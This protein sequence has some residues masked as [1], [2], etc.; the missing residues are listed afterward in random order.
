MS[1]HWDGC[2][3]IHPGCA[4]MELRRVQAENARLEREVARHSHNGNIPTQFGNTVSGPVP[5]FPETFA[6]RINAVVESLPSAV[7]TLTHPDFAPY[8]AEMALI[9]RI[10]GS[11]SWTAPAVDEPPITLDASEPHR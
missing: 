10:P 3:N 1:D 8:T 9:Q 5:C 6:E 4:V 2:W 7:V 11:A